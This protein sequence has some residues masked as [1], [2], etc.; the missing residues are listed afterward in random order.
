MGL[1]WFAEHTLTVETPGKKLVHGNQVD[2]WTTFTT[3]QIK[4]CWVEASPSEENKYRRNTT[5]ATFDVLIPAEAEPPDSRDRIRHP[6]KS[7]AYQ[8]EGE[9]MPVTAASGRLDHFF[10]VVTKWK[11]N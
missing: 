6:L 9:A 8:V 10:C 5:R 3:R 2:D 4:Y 1:P 11:V 7:G